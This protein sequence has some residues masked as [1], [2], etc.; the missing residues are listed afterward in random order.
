MKGVQ[1]APGPVLEE[2]DEVWV[3]FDR[4]EDVRESHAGV[5]VAG[6]TAHVESGSNFLLDVLTNVAVRFQRLDAAFW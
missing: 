4:A 1:V 2:S 5:D 6:A 3:L